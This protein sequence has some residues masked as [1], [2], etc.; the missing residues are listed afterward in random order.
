MFLFDVV[1]VFFEL[2][3][4]QTFRREYGIAVAGNVIGCRGDYFVFIL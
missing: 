2:F 3:K 1:R 4:R